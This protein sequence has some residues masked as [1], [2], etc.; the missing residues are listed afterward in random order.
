MMAELSTRTAALLGAATASVVIGVLADGPS[1]AAIGRQQHACYPAQF[2]AFQ[3]RK[4]QISDSV[5]K[6]TA[7]VRG[8]LD[9]C[10]PAAVDGARSADASL[11]L[12]CYELS[13]SSIRTRFL[14]S[15][16]NPFGTARIAVGSPRTLCV[17]SSRTTKRPAPV[18]L[19]CYS[20]S[21]PA[22]ANRISKTIGDAFSTS[23]DSIA[24]GRP[25]S[26]CTAPGR[27]GT[28]PLHL[29]CYSVTSETAARTIVLTDEWGVLRASLGRRD[30]LCIQSSLRL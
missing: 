27:G 17:S 8:P 4:V 12:T 16:S 9:V 28:A 21:S 22:N 6:F 25:V 30:R 26:F 20:V 11:Y 3:A 23:Q 24:V 10:P 14:G 7:I 13:A 29:M 5:A 15:V 19:T 1:A 2:T 18:R